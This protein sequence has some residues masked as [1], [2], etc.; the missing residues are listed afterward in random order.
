MIFQLIFFHFPMSY[1]ILFRHFSD[2]QCSRFIYF[3]YYLF[4]Y[5]FSFL[6]IPLHKSFKPIHVCFLVVNINLNG[7]LYV[8]TNFYSPFYNTFRCFF[9]ELA[10]VKCSLLG[11]C[12]SFISLFIFL[13][14]IFFVFLN[15]GQP[16]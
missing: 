14:Q 7:V 1:M 9:L 6:F 10:A 3:P 5:L 2:F 12:I 16:S 11:S 8:K 13:P 4:I 15:L